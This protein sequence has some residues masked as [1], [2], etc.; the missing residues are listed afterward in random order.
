MPTAVEAKKTP[1][2]LLD[3]IA[4][5]R[6]AA[7]YRNIGLTDTAALVLAAQSTVECGHGGRAGCFNFNVSNIMGSSPEGLYHVLQAPEC[8][9][10]DK[11]PQGGTV[12]PT[13]SVACPPG[14]VSYIPAGGSKFR[15]YTSLQ[16]GCADKLATLQKTWPAAVKALEL[17]GSLDTIAQS[18]VRALSSPRYF[19]ADERAYAGSLQSV[20]RTL[21]ASYEV[22]RAQTRLASLGYVIG[23]VD[24]VVGVRTRTAISKFQADLGLAVDGV[25]GPKTREALGV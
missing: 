25:L 18:Y 24:G 13:A 12:L 9:P 22:M 6:A 1:W 8:A 21:S 23:T 5:Y 4:A 15:A 7:V 19:T 3:L 14:Y 17:G 2:T 20:A 16:A 10:T 11:V